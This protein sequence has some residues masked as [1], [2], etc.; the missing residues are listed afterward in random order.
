MLLLLLLLR[1]SRK[2]VAVLGPMHERDSMFCMSRRRGSGLFFF[3]S[4]GTEFRALDKQTKNRQ[5]TN[6]EGEQSEQSLWKHAKGTTSKHL[7]HWWYPSSPSFFTFLS[8]NSNSKSKFFTHFF[9][10]DLF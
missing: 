6:R 2:L 9:Y 1:K 8:E 4:S 3:D 5:E 10:L 7:L